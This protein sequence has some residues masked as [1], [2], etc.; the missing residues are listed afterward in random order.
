MVLRS[1]PD[2]FVAHNL[3]R[4]RRGICPYPPAAEK[5]ALSGGKT[6]AW[7]RSKRVS[8]ESV[9]IAPIH[10]CEFGACNGGVFDVTN[11]GGRV[12]PAPGLE[13]DLR[14]LLLRPWSFGILLPIRI[15]AGPAGTFSFD[16]KKGFA[17]VGVGGGVGGRGLN[18][19]PLWGDTEKSYSIL[20]GGSVSVNAAGPIGFQRRV[21]QV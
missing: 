20:K 19:G 7:K 12:Q 11:G 8:G 13:S 6:A 14:A 9:G 3:A 5:K 4:L 16:L 15:P 1:I 2:L 18:G 10:G 21:A 17:C